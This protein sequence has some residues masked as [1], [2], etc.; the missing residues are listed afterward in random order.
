MSDL[1]K[2]KADIIPYSAEYS[3]DVRSWIDSAETYKAVCRG[4]EYPPPEDVVD[5]WQRKEVSSYLL[6]ASGKPVAY[7]EL[8]ER[9]MD[10]AIE[11]AHLIVVPSKRSQGFGTKMVQLMYERG[12]QKKSIIKVLA[13]LFGDSTDALGCFTKA[14]FEILGTA[15][16]TTGLKLAKMVDK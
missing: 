2:V 8:W 14:G 6:F 13:S 10:M 16:Y 15:N 7:A 12:C 9:K 11:I 1:S 3:R 4:M 5:G